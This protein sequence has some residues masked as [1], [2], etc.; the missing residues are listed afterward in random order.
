MILQ[1]SQS[2]FTEA[3]TFIIQIFLVL[4]IVCSPSFGVPPPHTLKRG[5]QTTTT[6]LGLLKNQKVTFQAPHD[7]RSATDEPPHLFSANGPERDGRW[8][9]A[10]N[11]FC[12]QEPPLSH[13]QVG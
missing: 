8:A 2:F 9:K 7:G 5:L 4:A 11:K 1:C 12:S 10:P 3:R 6:E 13:L